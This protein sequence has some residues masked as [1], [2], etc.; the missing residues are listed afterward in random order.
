MAEKKDRYWQMLAVTLVVI[1][2]LACGCAG[3]SAVDHGGGLRSE[4]GQIAFMRAS[5]STDRT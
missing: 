2:T 4:E 1:T 3:Q 5:T